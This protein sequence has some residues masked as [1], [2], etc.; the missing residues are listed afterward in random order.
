MIETITQGTQVITQYIQ[1]FLS[2]L[3]KHIETQT[4]TAQS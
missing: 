4:K 3:T 1:Y 2:I